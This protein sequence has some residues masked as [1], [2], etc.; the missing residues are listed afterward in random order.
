[1]NQHVYSYFTSKSLAALEGEVKQ[2][3]PASRSGH[4]TC[5]R[6]SPHMARSV[7]YTPWDMAVSLMLTPS[8]RLTLPADS[9]APPGVLGGGK[10]SSPPPTAAALSTVILV[11][12]DIDSTSGCWLRLYYGTIRKTR[13]LCLWFSWMRCH[14]LKP[15]LHFLPPQTIS[16]TRRSIKIASMRVCVCVCLCVFQPPSLFCLSHQNNHWNKFTE[17]R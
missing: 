13:S 5:R 2:A 12:V 10:S 11:G 1:M 9:S 16:A 3:M 17:W 15:K 7:K 4:A 14:N 6:C 8:D